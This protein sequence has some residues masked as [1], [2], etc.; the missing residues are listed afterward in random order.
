MFEAIRNRYKRIKTFVLTHR[1]HAPT[2]ALVTGFIWDNLTLGRPDQLFDNVVLLFYLL[3]AGGGIVFLNRMRE[4]GGTPSLWYLVLIQFS[5]GNLASAMF[6]LYGI[7]GT[8]ISNWP[9]FLLLI[10]LLVGNEFLKGKYLFLSV[11]AVIYSVLLFSY[12][13]LI[14]PILVRSI[15][16]GIFLLSGVVGL[17]LSGL[18]I[19]AVYLVAPQTVIVRKRILAG[20]IIGVYLVFNALYFTHL[21]PPVPLALRDIAVYHHVERSTS[22]EYLVTTEDI[23]WYAFW[24]W[25]G[26]TFHYATD[27]RAYCFTSVFAPARINTPVFHVW[28]FYDEAGE[29]WREKSRV[30]FPIEGGRDEGFRG[31]SIKAIDEP[32][33][34]RCSVETPQGALIGRKNFDAIQVPTEPDFVIKER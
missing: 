5:F 6:V 30:S 34:W 15:G 23:P 21:I 4:R 7:S 25:F 26:T 22:G 29:K 3:L 28:E 19:G 17:M 12:A 18:F 2:A 27:A 20:S 13:I 14:V 11:N 10:G 9:F 16:P 32:G 8:F 33:E 24:R 1:R 31:Y